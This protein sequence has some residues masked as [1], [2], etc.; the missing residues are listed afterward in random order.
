MQRVLRWVSLLVL[1]MFLVAC[2]N[3]MDLVNPPAA[4]VNSK[5]LTKSELNTRID[6]LEVGMKKNPDTS[7]KQPTRAELTYMVTEQFVVQN[8]LIDLATQKKIT[9]TTSEI[10][11]QV[12]E[13]RAA[14]AKNSKDDFDLV[15]S[16]QLGFKDSKDEG[17]REFCTYFFVQ[18]KLAET[19]VTTDTVTAEIRAELK[20]QAA[21]KELQAHGAHI[22]VAEEAVAKSIIDE[23]NNGGDFTALAA[24]Y[25]TDPG[26]KDKGGDLGWVGKGAFVPE[27]EKALFDDLKVGELTQV[28]VKSQYGFHIIKLLGREERG[29][30]DMANSDS[31]IASRLPSTINQRRNEEIAKLI[32][33][34]RKKATDEK[35]IEVA[36]TEVS[37]TPTVDAATAPTATPAP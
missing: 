18:K 36:P 7:A 9:A 8:V 3:P 12:E 23:L 26:S 35:R 2:G 17:F 28:P 16:D 24:K 31:E 1:G 32:E 33:A 34:E 6:R 14:V 19:L 10:D 20:A 25:S 22:L 5:V 29:Q 21:K 37:L 15:I 13:F 11:A 30:F 4:R 27:F